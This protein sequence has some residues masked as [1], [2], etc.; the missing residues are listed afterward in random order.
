MNDG[1]KKLLNSIPTKYKHIACFHLVCGLLTNAPRKYFQENKYAYNGIGIFFYT[2]TF[3]FVLV[4]CN[5][6]V[7]Q[8]S[9]ITILWY[10]ICLPRIAEQF[11]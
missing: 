8:N 6:I 7:H 3:S 9:H 2:T 1:F 11:I 4:K 5:C 10:K